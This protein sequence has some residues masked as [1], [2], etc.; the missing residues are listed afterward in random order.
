M[1]LRGLAGWLHSTMPGTLF[2][3]NRSVPAIRFTKKPRRRSLHGQFHDAI[4]DAF[5]AWRR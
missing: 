1:S 2:G 3:L 5:D 4:M